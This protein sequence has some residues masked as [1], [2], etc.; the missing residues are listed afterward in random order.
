[1][2]VE[3]DSGGSE[4]HQRQLYRVG[5]IARRKKTTTTDGLTGRGFLLSSGSFRS[6][7]RR[8]RRWL[9]EEDRKPEPEPEQEQEPERGD[10][11]WRKRRVMKETRVSRRSLGWAGWNGGLDQAWGGLDGRVDGSEGGEA[12]EGDGDEERRTSRRSAGQ[13]VVDVDVHLSNTNPVQFSW[14]WRWRAYTSCTLA[15][16]LGA[17]TVACRRTRY[18]FGYL[19]V[20]V[21]YALWCVLGGAGRQDWAGRSE[22]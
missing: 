22:C 12:G 20:S 4:R 9:I 1:M 14:C 3:G 21:H 6:R 15:W 10:V 8:R 16:W 18:Q 7:R 5:R 19:K 17:R 2:V 13:R 11:G